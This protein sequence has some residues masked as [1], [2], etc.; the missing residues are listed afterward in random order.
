MSAVISVGRP[1]DGPDL[2]VLGHECPQPVIVTRILPGYAAVGERQVAVSVQTG[3]DPQ[4]VGRQVAFELVLADHVEDAIL[5]GCH[6]EPAVAQRPEL[7]V[8]TRVVLGHPLRDAVDDRLQLQREM[9]AEEF[10]SDGQALIL[11]NQHSGDRCLRIHGESPD[12][13]KIPLHQS[14]E[15]TISFSADER[16]PPLLRRCILIGVLGVSGGEGRVAGGEYM[17][18]CLLSYVLVLLQVFIRIH[19]GHKFR[20][21]IDHPS[22]I[23][24]R[25]VPGRDHFECIEYVVMHASSSSK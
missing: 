21:V 7:P 5:G 3:R 20:L 13:E 25:D 2:G 24:I 11:W 23:L 18:V 22:E 9:N 4:G 10:L 19:A 8:A 1:Q 17:D 16:R 15:S 12:V 6:V 14:L